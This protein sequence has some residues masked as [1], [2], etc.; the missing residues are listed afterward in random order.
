[1]KEGI[2]RVIDQL[3]QRSLHPLHL[4]QD[5]PLVGGEQGAVVGHLLE[6]G[7]AL[8]LVAGLLEVVPVTER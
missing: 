2:R 7:A 1:M 5:L 8:E 3:R 6:H 4:S